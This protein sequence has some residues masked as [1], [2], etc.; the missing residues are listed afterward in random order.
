MNRLH[1]G[2]FRQQSLLLPILHQNTS[3][4]ST[5]GLP[6]DVVYPPP[7]ASILFPLDDGQYLLL[8]LIVFAGP[9]LLKTFIVM[10]LPVALAMNSEIVA[11]F[12]ADLEA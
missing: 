1:G 2:V 4:Q 7:K 12:N 11:L 5:S 9:R 3:N 10:L 6:H 8:T